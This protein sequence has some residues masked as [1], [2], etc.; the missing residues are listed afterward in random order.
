M[1]GGFLDKGAEV[2]LAGVE[3]VELAEDAELVEDAEPAELAFLL[4]NPIFSQL[5]CASADILGLAFSF[6]FY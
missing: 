1:C 5:V 2:D 3:V 6:W 4:V